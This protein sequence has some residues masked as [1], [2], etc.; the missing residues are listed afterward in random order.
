MSILSGVTLRN[1]PRRREVRQSKVDVCCL[2]KQPLPKRGDLRLL[3]FLPAVNQ[4]VRPDAF[5][6]LGE[7]CDK[8]A[9]NQIVLKEDGGEAGEAFALDCSL[10][11]QKEMAEERPGRMEGKSVG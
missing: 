10:Q 1:G 7:R 4:I 9:R 8:P 5:R 6:A 2:F 3:A 11:G